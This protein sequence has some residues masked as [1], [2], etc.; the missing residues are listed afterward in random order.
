M[1]EKETETGAYK[2][3]YLLNKDV[4]FLFILFVML[5]VII[6]VSVFAYFHKDLITPGRLF[7]CM[8]LI[9]AS[10]CWSS[11]KDGQ[12]SKIMQIVYYVVIPFTEFIVT[13]LLHISNWW[14][15]GIIILYLVALAGVYKH[16]SEGTSGSQHSS[17]S[18]RFLLFSLRNMG[19][20]GRR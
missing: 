12:L 18:E 17:L 5:I 13:N 9:S 10:I 20:R 8:I 19:R 15:I 2:E 11:L 14:G 7:H 16:D 1:I 6:T 4:N 3:H